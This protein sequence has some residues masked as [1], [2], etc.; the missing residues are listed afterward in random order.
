MVKE[1]RTSE[2]QH[3]NIKIKLKYIKEEENKD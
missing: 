2:K 1:G 3:R